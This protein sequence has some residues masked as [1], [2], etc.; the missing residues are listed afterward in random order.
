MNKEKNSWIKK[1]VANYMS[2]EFASY[3]AV[4]TMLDKLKD[5]KG[6]MS[7]TFDEPPL[8]ETERNKD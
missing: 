2:D 1:L 5:S 8:F 3:E 4:L 7:V 6:E